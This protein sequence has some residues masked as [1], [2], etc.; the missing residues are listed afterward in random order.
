[1][2]HLDPDHVPSYHNMPISEVVREN[3]NKQTKQKHKKREGRGTDSQK[4]IHG[5]RKSEDGRESGEVSGVRYTG[6][7]VNK[8]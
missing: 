2:R 6:S 8:L 5:R 3:Q 1:M 4:I 7:G